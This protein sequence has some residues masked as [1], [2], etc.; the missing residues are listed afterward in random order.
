MRQ[1][2]RQKNFSFSKIKLEYSLTFWVANV[3]N[4]DIMQIVSYS[5]R[6]SFWNIS[7]FISWHIP[8]GVIEYQLD[9]LSLIGSF[10]SNFSFSNFWRCVLKIFLLGWEIFSILD[11]PSSRY[12]LISN[13]VSKKLAFIARN[14]FHPL[15]FAFDA[16]RTNCKISIFL[17]NE[18]ILF[19]TIY[20]IEVE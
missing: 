18:L 8:K 16:K 7:D 2:P 5:R 1:I 14:V 15:F 19:S 4:T 13:F 3:N 12:L 6:N 17:V 11:F 9:F 10:T 20:V